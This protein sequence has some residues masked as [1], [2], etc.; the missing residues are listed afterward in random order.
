MRLKRKSDGRIYNFKGVENSGDLGYTLHLETLIRA[1]NKQLKKKKLSY[2][3]YYWQDIID[4]MNCYE[5][6]D[7][8][9]GAL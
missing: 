4:A 3:Y 7:E 8:I 9:V 2:T 1:N 5:E 6:T